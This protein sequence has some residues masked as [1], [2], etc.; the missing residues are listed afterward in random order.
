MDNVCE[1]QSKRKLDDCN[2]TL[3]PKGRPKKANCNVNVIIK[4]QLIIDGES[5][6]KINKLAGNSLNVL[7]LKHFQALNVVSKDTSEEHF[8][9]F[10]QDF[11]NKINSSESFGEKQPC[12]TNI[13]TAMT[14]FWICLSGPNVVMQDPAVIYDY[15]CITFPNF[16]EHVATDSE[17]FHNLF[18]SNCGCDATPCGSSVYPKKKSFWWYL[19]PGKKA[20]SASYFKPFAGPN[21]RRFFGLTYHAL[22][23]L[24]KPEALFTLKILCSMKDIS[25]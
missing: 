15:C 13:V 23:R 24:N 10:D 6:K 1:T 4:T 22:K 8:E 19:I 12:K 25:Q 17:N 20:S 18:Y 14:Y 2:F 7:K 16:M 9:F 3:C 21:F 5:L 11:Q